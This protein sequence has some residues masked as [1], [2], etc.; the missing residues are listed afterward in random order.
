MNKKLMGNESHIMVAAP[1]EP[2]IP[3]PEL[4]PP[5]PPKPEIPYRDGKKF[6]LHEHIPPLPLGIPYQACRKDVPA[7]VLQENSMLDVVLHYPPLEGGG[8]T[9]TVVDFVIDKEIAVKDG[10]GAQLVS[11]W[12]TLPQGRT[13]VAA[14]IFD[15]LYY[16][17]KAGDMKLP[18]CVIEDHKRSD[19]IRVADRE[20]T[21]E[22]AVYKEYDARF[23]GKEMARFHG[24]YTIYINVPGS[25]SKRPV[26]VILMEHLEFK[27]LQQ[28][29]LA[30]YT[31][32]SRISIIASVL[33]AWAVFDHHGI[34]PNWDCFWA[35]R[36]LICG[37]I[38]DAENPPRV[39][40]I[41]FTSACVRRL[42]RLPVPTDY[43][44]EH[45]YPTKFWQSDLRKLK[46]V[47]DPKDWAEGVWGKE[48]VKKRE[49]EETFDKEDKRVQELTT[50]HDKSMACKGCRVNVA[51]SDTLSRVVGVRCRALHEFKAEGESPSELTRGEVVVLVRKEP[52]GMSIPSRCELSLT[53]NRLVACSTY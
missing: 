16:E 27:T 19:Y 47:P 8:D 40:Y 9:T 25:E 42:A 11:G 13:Y 49:G 20:Y 3:V 29:A 45:K 43:M 14:K 50:E 41:G 7:R 28:V 52:S 36:V 2:S 33:T 12:A 39:A 31:E 44:T 37:P 15:A 10:R 22:A 6:T 4:P 32:K 17:N 34:K 48:S 53:C 26:R 1:A 5:H 30:D 46:I 21:R 18:V 38:G 51:T 23:G 35:T 24:T